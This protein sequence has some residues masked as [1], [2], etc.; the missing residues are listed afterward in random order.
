L[1]YKAYF[2]GGRRET[3]WYINPEVKPHPTGTLSLVILAKE[4]PSILAVSCDRAD[5]RLFAPV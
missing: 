3:T 4:M 1:I 2:F 5:L